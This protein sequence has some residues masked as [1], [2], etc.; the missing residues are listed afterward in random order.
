M[1]V[2]YRARDS[3]LNRAVAVKVLKE[4]RLGTELA[5]FRREVKALLATAHPH[6]VKLLDAGEVEGRSFLVMELLP[7]GTLADVLVAA[8]RNR[9]PAA[10]VAALA[11]ALLDA[12]EFAHAQGLVHRDIKPGNV[13]FDTAERPVLMDF[14]LAFDAGGEAI[15][16]AGYVVGTPQY[17]SPEAVRG[18]A[19]AP[20]RDLWSVGV[21]AYECL[22][23]LPPF[24]GRDANEIARAVARCEPRPL[25]E[26]PPG[27]LIVRPSHAGFPSAIRRARTA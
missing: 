1:G 9:L 21:I 11:D 8:P 10:R 15:T 24:E 2:V 6:V 27:R 25:G 12:L 19:S 4:G 22:A 5:R 20:A 18:E 7:A 16:S 3:T 23:G 17:L 26:L 14:G 13:M